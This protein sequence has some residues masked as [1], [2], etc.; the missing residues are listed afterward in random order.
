MLKYISFKKLNAKWKNVEAY[1]CAATR[2][3]E[4]GIWTVPLGHLIQH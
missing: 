1:C 2:K 4:E 3:I